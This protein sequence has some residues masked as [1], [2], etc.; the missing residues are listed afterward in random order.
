MANERG[1]TTSLNQKQ[2]GKGT[3]QETC[4]FFYI[5]TPQADFIH[6]RTQ[7][8]HASKHAVYGKFTIFASESPMPTRI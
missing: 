8:L 2:S 7:K 1:R 4:P 3:G 6:I 5:Y